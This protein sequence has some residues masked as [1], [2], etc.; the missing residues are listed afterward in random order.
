M[1]VSIQY[2]FALVCS[3]LSADRN[4]V[5]GGGRLKLVKLGCFAILASVLTPA[6][7]GNFYLGGTAGLMDSDRNGFDDATSAGVLAGWEFFS[8]DIFHVLAETEFTSTVSDGDLRNGG[9]K[10][11]WDLDTRAV[12]LGSRLGDRAYVKVRFGYSWTDLS[13]DFAGRSRSDSETS[14]SWG[15]ALGWNFTSH[16]GMQVDG[17]LVDS[18]VTYWNLGLLY[19]F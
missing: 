19:R 8:K 5:R 9:E 3:M 7:A 12:Y 11:D 6:A 16:W 4:M 2:L 1:V 14:L 17:T 13:T 10:G 18:D 15:G